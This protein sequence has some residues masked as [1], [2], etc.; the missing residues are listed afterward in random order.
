MRQ[1][2][3]LGP[4][5]SK[6]ASHCER[7]ALVLDTRLPVCGRDAGSSALLSHMHGLRRLGYAVS[8][9]V[10]DNSS[11]SDDAVRDLA[12]QGITVC[13][14]P[15]YSS[16]EE[17]LRRQAGSV[18][19]VYLHRVSIAS[20]YLNLVRQ[21]LPRAR[22]LYSVADLH[23]VRL[24][25]QALVEDR[26]ELRLLSRRCKQE[27]L[28]AALLSD[29]VLTHSEEEATLLRQVVPAARVHRVPWEVP[30]RAKQPAFADRHGV[31]FIGN[32]AHAPNRDAAHWLIEEVMPLVW[33]THRHI[34][35]LLVGSEMPAGIRSLSRPG[36]IV[37]GHVLELHETLLDRVRLTVA[38]LRFGA[39][40]KGKVLD[41]LAAGVPCV[42]SEVAAEGIALGK[43]LRSLVT[44]NAQDMASAICTLHEEEGLHQ[45]VSRAGRHLLKV[46][47]SKKVVTNALIAAIEGAPLSQIDPGEI[48]ASATRNLSRRVSRRA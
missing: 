25:R 43:S 39:G 15:V 37:L 27:E 3:R 14:P 35:C 40:V 46:Q 8:L 32:Y 30:V 22:V 24:E 23:H 7:R 16:V 29:V 19:V 1:R 42:M 2:R 20:R 17:V 10:S 12:R 21:Y 18:D 28:T 44:R 41:S 36:V 38:P 4:S 13:R 9:A 48:P 26:P 47:N 5:G 6:P 31:A 11:V 33:E 45:R 34:T